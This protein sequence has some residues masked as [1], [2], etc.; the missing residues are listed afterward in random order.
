MNAHTYE[1]IGRFT[2]FPEAHWN[3][4]FPSMPFGELKEDSY[5]KN[6]TWG[7][8]TREESL[9]LAHELGKLTLPS[10]RS[11][12]YGE[13]AHTFSNRQVKEDL[14]HDE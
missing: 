8:M 7:I 10:Q 11:V 6:K 9:R 3:R 1:D 13:I 12:N 14:L 2:V 4:M 5:E